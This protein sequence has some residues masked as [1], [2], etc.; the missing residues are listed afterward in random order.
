M[1]FTCDQQL[2]E[3]ALIS[4]ERATSTRTPL[5]ITKGILMDAGQGIVT[6]IATDLEIE[7]ERKVIANVEEQG[8]AVVMGSLFTDIIKKMPKAPITIELNGNKVNIT[9]GDSEFNLVALDPEQFS[10]EQMRDEDKTVPITLNKETFVELI[11]QT[12]FA[13][14]T[15]ES[16]KEL[17]GVKVEIGNGQIRLIA[18]DGYRLATRA[19]SVE[20]KDSF[21]F[22]IPGKAMREIAKVDDDAEDIQIALGEKLASFNMGDT[23]IFARLYDVSRYVDW[24]AF[25]P[26]TSAM[27]IVV[28][29]GNLDTCVDRASLF[30]EGTNSLLQFDIKDSIVITSQSEFGNGREVVP[31][32]SGEAEITIGFNAK[33]LKDV[34]KVVKDDEITLEMVENVKPALIKPIS[35]ESYLYLVLPVRIH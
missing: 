7:I 18:I 13:V 11:N 26:E 10:S 24:K 29:R 8:K 28:D 32:N 3:K 5:D 21:E 22:L 15:D 33:Y 17:T 30:A 27:S 16:K 34:L 2:L 12:I 20:T 31:I 19:E 9:A 4:V 23:K 1:K 25:L 6:L 14:S 35:G